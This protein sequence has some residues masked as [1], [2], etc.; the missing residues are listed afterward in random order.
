[1]FVKLDD[2]HH[3][4]CSI[5]TNKFSSD[6]DNTDPEIR[7]HL[8][9]LSSSQKCDHWFCHSCILKEQIRIAEENNGRIPKWIRCMI[10]R[11]KTSFNPAE[12]K[13]HRLLIDLLGRAQEFAAAEVKMEGWQIRNANARDTLEW[14]TQQKSMKGSG[15]DVVNIDGNCEEKES[16]AKHPKI[17]TAK[18]G[19]GSHECVDSY[20][21][22]SPFASLESSHSRNSTD[23][24]VVST[25]SMRMLKFQF[26]RCH[27]C[28]VTKAGECFEII[29]RKKEKA[30]ICKR[31]QMLSK[32]GNTS[33]KV[34]GDS[35]SLPS[36]TS[37]ESLP[38]K[39]GVSTAEGF[40][41]REIRFGKVIQR[42]QGLGRKPNSVIE[43]QQQQR[44]ERERDSEKSTENGGNFQ[45]DNNC[46]DPSPL[47]IQDSAPINIATGRDTDAKA[48]ANNNNDQIKLR[49][50]YSADPIKQANNADDEL[51]P[52]ATSTPTRVATKPPPPER[53][54]QF[55]SFGRTRKG[56][57]RE[58]V[59]RKKMNIEV[60]KI[61]GEWLLC[62]E[63][64]RLNPLQAATPSRKVKETFATH[65]GV[66][67][68]CINSW[69]YRRR[70]KL[71]K[72]LRKN[73]EDQALILP[74]KAAYGNALSQ[75]QVQLRNKA[76]PV[77]P[78]SVV[79][80]SAVRTPNLNNPSQYES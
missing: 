61:L 76:N 66:D 16:D 60:N 15:A 52:G 18:A 31:C 78:P 56:K 58:K 35:Q 53:Q 32:Q 20:Q 48:A 69:F 21:D 9:V 27:N 30:A 8:P 24:E 68:T 11:E 6:L 13:Y 77:N 45:R 4:K 19:E 59:L 39:N 47:S 44:F 79:K 55:T 50:V 75:L 46:K 62:P 12:P 36:S 25:A 23:T 57:E 40:M 38:R 71:K 65:L 63:N 74:M 49:D 72:A 34:C 10:C 26:L 42:Q 7:K 37:G 2:E 51:S 29:Q 41:P 17:W 80:P 54:R 67:I 64:M 1:M 5:C 73:G 14:S 33:K 28:K 3:T 43:K 22:S 70:K